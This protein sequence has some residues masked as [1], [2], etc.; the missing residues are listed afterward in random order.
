MA[1]LEPIAQMLGVTVT[2]M[3]VVVGGSLGLVVL[4]IVIKKM[5]EIA[6]KMFAVGC[7]TIVIVG[8]G[9]YLFFV[10]SR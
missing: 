8:V 5:T 2:Q 3:V 7:F 6:V 1:F 10:F 9:L 4:W